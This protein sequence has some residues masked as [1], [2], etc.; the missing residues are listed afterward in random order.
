MK[1][2]EATE[3]LELTIMLII[4]IGITMALT[5]GVFVTQTLLLNVIQK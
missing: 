2:Y 5:H 1:K 4:L 3:K